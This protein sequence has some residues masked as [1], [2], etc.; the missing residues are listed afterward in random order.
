MKCPP[1]AV[2]KTA[3]SPLPPPLCWKVVIC[4]TFASS[5]ILWFAQQFLVSRPWETVIAWKETLEQQSLFSRFI[6]FKNSWEWLH[7]NWLLN[8]ASFFN[9][10][11][12]R[13]RH[14]IRKPQHSSVDNLATEISYITETEDVFY[15]YKVS[16]TSK[17]SD[18]EVSQG[19]SP[20]RR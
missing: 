6:T 10:R 20:W 12:P 8:P 19:R 1:V 16:P 5:I 15:T 7:H 18:S 4:G 17:D 9:R 3:L 11:S 13:L 2:Q 14:E